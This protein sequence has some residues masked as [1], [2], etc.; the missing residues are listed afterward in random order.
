ML[1][2]KKKK[3]PEISEG[4]FR[5]RRN[6]YQEFPFIDAGFVSKGFVFSKLEC[7]N[8]EHCC[9]NVNSLI[10]NFKVGNSRFSTQKIK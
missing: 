8:S 3:S 1:K 7:K 9:N 2:V 4:G 10:I 6:L 5:A